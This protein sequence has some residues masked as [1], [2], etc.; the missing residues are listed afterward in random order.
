MAK[1]VVKIKLNEKKVPFAEVTTEGV[2]GAVAVSDS[3]PVDKSMVP[4]EQGDSIRFESP[5][6]TVRIRFSGASPFGGS[7]E[8][9]GDIDHE[10]VVP[11][12]TF[13]FQ[14]GVVVKDNDKDEEIA[15]PGTNQGGAVVVGGRGL[16]PGGLSG[17]SPPSRP[18]DGN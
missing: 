8:V 11:I 13:P 6:G 12:G 2:S 9:Q 16:G 4:A 5:H 14:C 17:G 15:W 1:H 3:Q 18:G 10:V 7:P